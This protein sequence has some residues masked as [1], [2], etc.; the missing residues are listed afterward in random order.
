M[1][2]PWSRGAHL[3]HR[4]A[5]S[6]ICRPLRRRDR[7]ARPQRRR[8]PC[9]VVR[10]H[11]RHARSPP[12]RVWSVTVRMLR[13][14]R[15]GASKCSVLTASYID[16]DLFGAATVDE[17]AHARRS[18]PTRHEKIE[19]AASAKLAQRR[20]DRRLR[21]ATSSRIHLRAS[22]RGPSAAL[23][24]HAPPSTVQFHRVQQRRQISGFRSSSTSNRCC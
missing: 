3:R 21:L 19:N 8:Y 13:D 23:H 6:A 17:A 7:R 16:V 20:A 9:H 12:T 1:T 5:F 10:G 22:R 18:A 24:H 15:A 4:C 2:C 11:V 14:D